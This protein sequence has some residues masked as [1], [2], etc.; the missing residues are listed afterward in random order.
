MKHNRFYVCVITHIVIFYMKSFF[1][2]NIFHIIHGT[3]NQFSFSAL[4]LGTS[5]LIS[6]IITASN[7]II[8]TNDVIKLLHVQ[9]LRISMYRKSNYLLLI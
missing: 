9:L 7:N 4:W 2:E 3:L 1:L 5:A 8:D 6:Y